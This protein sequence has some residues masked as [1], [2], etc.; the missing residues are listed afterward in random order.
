[1]ERFRFRP[2]NESMKQDENILWTAVENRDRGFD[3]KFFFGVMTTGVYCR[4]SCGCRLPLRKNVRF[5]ETPEQA[6]A[7]GLRPCLRCRPLATLGVDPDTERIRKTCDY[8]RANL[9]TELPLGL[10]ADQ[11]GLS[12]FH[13]QRSF[14]AV[15][16]V[17]PRQFVEAC[18]LDALKGNLRNPRH[19]V[20][21]AI[22]ESGFG[23]GSRV[24]ERVDTRLGMTP[25]TYRSGGKG[26]RISWV[27][28]DSALGRM[29]IG[30]T[31]RG[32]CFVQFGSSDDA[33]LEMLKAEYPAAVVEPMAEP[34]PKEFHDWMEAL[35]DHLR[36]QQPKLDLPLDLQATAFQMKVWQYLQ[37]QIPYGSV[38]SYS[39]VAEGIGQP[40]AARAVARACASN[41]VALVIPCH[42]VIRGTGEL[43]GYRWGLERKRVL[44]DQERRAATT[45][46]A[47]RA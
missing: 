24:Y 4:P 7:A 20:T 23:S 31:D 29:M 34:Y 2:Q 35:G 3:G 36:G 47:A 12:P 18:R 28:T 32:L 27:S 13:F 25:A 43:G 39:E 40:A 26:V 30:A 14:K 41:R 44:I 42:R 22:Y 8:V 11:A 33:L 16:G 1:M 21:D 45:T 5:F 9:D 15:M 19:S 37:Q 17:T 38:Q 6:E 46:A 10:L